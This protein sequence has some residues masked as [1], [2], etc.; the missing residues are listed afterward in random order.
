MSCVSLARN[1]LHDAALA[2]VIA[3]QIVNVTVGLSLPSVLLAVLG[4]GVGV[5]V[6]GQ[7]VRR[8]VI[9]VTAL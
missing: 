5:R 4:R 7:D 9:A 1:G 2:G 6:T 8:W 3:S